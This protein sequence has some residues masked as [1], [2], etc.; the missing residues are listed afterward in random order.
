MEASESPWVLRKAAYWSKRDWLIRF[1][2][3][4]LI[5][6]PIYKLLDIIDIVFYSCG[7]FLFGFEIGLEGGNK[8]FGG[9]GKACLAR[10]GSGS[11]GG[12][13]RIF[14]N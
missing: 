9:S 10:T 5:F 2:G 13:K 1:L 8:G 7:S 3:F 14:F 12:F 6:C 4:R 11:E